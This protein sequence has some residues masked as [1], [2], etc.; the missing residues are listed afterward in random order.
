[1]FGSEGFG[2]L[3][4]DD[5]CVFDEK[6]GVVI[7]DE[8]AVFIVDFERVLL[9]NRYPQFTE[10]MG[11]SIF[12]NF[13][14]VTV[15]MEKVNVIGNLAHLVCKNLD[16]ERRFGRHGGTVYVVFYRFSRKTEE[17]EK[18]FNHKEHKK[19]KEGEDGLGK[20]NEAFSANRFREAVPRSILG[21]R[22]GEY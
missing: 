13:L 17:R 2:G 22:F 4:F 12:I 10:A 9:V 21:F 18:G 6:V 16:I 8:G 7:A 19:N 1:V 3:E 14:E 15:A 5:E 11:E 20:A